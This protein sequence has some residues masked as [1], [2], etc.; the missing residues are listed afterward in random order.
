MPEGCQPL[1]QQQH[2]IEQDAHQACHDHARP[3][4]IDRV[5]THDSINHALAWS[6]DDR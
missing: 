1:E 5:F 3:D 6:P 2:G 4:E